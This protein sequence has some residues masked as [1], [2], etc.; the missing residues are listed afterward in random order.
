MFSGR[1]YWPQTEGK[2]LMRNAVENVRELWA[3][4]F[5][6][7]R[8]YAYRATQGIL[9]GHKRNPL[10]PSSDTIEEIS[11]DG[12]A[13]SFETT[14][15]NADRIMA[16]RD[17]QKRRKVL[18]GFIRNGCRN[19]IK[20]YRASHCPNLQSD[21]I[22]QTEE[23]PDGFEE[24]VLSLPPV[25]RKTAELFALGKTQSKIAELLG[26]DRCTVFRHQERIR[27]LLGFDLFCRFVQRSFT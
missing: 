19:S 12:I 16:W 2:D 25:F 17:L 27:E 9:A 5:K 4:E 15:K 11:A 6:A 23:T 1:Q 8:A 18:L 24:L 3:E 20:K 22:D 7:I 10:F 14:T 26:V 21:P 13:E